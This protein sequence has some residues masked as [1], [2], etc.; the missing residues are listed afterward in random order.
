VPSVRRT[1]VFDG[2]L[3]EIAPHRTTPMGPPIGFWRKLPQTSMIGA[4]LR[5]FRIPILSASAGKQRGRVG[6]WRRSSGPR[7]IKTCK[8]CWYYGIGRGAGRPTVGDLEAQFSHAGAE[9]DL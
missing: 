5:F 4:L 7:F 9:P 1:S 2:D 8:L 6:S 3:R